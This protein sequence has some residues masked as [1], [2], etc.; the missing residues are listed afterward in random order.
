[1]PESLIPTFSEF[2][3]ARISREQ[4]KIMFISGMVPMPATLFIIGIATSP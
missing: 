3:A 2:E 1:M 4:W